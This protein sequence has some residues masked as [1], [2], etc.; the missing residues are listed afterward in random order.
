MRSMPWRVKMPVCSAS[1][2]G[3]PRVQ[4]PADAAVLALGVL[5]HADHVDVRG[6]AAGQRRLG[7]RQQPHRTQVHVLPETLAQRQDQV[8]RRDVVRHARV[9]DGAQVNRVELQQARDAVGVQHAA[10]CQVVVAAPRDA[11]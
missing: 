2:C 8:A 4:A 9:A 3:V 11:R 10:V 5:P 7:A 1:S 6:A